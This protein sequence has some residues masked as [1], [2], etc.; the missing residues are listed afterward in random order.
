MTLGLTCLD[1]ELYTANHWRL[2]RGRELWRGY[3]G[4][5]ETWRRQ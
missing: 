2:S 1:G 5:Y 4:D 3:A